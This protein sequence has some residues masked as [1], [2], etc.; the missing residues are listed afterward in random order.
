MRFDSTLALL[1]SEHDR[2]EQDLHVGM[3]VYWLNTTVETELPR[4]GLDRVVFHYARLVPATTSTTLNDAFLASLAEAVPDAVARLAPLPLS[5]T[6]VACT[7]S[8]FTGNDTHHGD[9]VATA[10]DALVATLNRL[11]AE[12]IALITPYPDAMTKHEVDAFNSAGIG[13]T[14]SASLG[15]TSGWAGVPSEDIRGLIGQVDQGAIREADAVVLSC[16]GWRT[17]HLVR[18]L[19][20]TLG[21][22]VLTSN[23]SLA[24][25]AVRLAT[26]AHAGA[27]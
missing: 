12:R 7:A 19:E 26:R 15:C 23:L 10:F 2:I 1:R 11:Q 3:V 25:H 5:S 4:M 6:L 9:G 17:L 20:E 22:P 21:R 16:T 18:E 8:G 27:G 14:A 13:V 24:V